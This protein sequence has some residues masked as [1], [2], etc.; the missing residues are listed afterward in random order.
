MI[1]FDKLERAAERKGMTINQACEKA[2]ICRI[3]YY[4]WKRGDNLPSMRTLGDLLKILRL[5]T[6]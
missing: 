1:D 4:R 6:A 3:T 5:K 2:G